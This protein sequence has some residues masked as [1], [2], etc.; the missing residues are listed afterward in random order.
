M[1]QHTCIP[2]GIHSVAIPRSAVAVTGERDNDLSKSIKRLVPKGKLFLELTCATDHKYAQQG[3]RRY[4]SM[5]SEPWNGWGV[6]RQLH[7]GPYR[8]LQTMENWVHSS[9]H[10]E[11]SGTAER[12]FVQLK[13]WFPVL[14]Y[15]VTVDLQ[16]VTSV[17]LITCCVVLHNVAKYWHCGWAQRMR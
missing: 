7:S 12:C 10:F 1:H 2:L 16:K 11:E 17:S 8:N 4:S 3:Y 6:I 9:L 15:T 5:H 13:M 14:R